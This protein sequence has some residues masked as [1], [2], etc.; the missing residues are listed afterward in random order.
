MPHRRDGQ[1]GTGNVLRKH[2][3]FASTRDYFGPSV[4]SDSLTR[5]VS[6]STPACS[7]RWPTGQTCIVFS[8]I[9]SRSSFSACGYAR[10]A[11]VTEHRSR[12]CSRIGKR[13]GVP[14]SSVTTLEAF[15][16]DTVVGIRRHGKGSHFQIKMCVSRTPC[17]RS[18]PGPVTPV[19]MPP[20]GPAVAASRRSPTAPARTIGSSAGRSSA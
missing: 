11:A 12:T 9:R 3:G 13:S 20:R 16:Q 1:W 5:V 6:V 14:A 8:R 15:G 2:R 10:S 17:S 7:K 19:C 18:F 4:I